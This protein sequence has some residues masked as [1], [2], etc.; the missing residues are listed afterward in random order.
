VKIPLIASH[1]AGHVAARFLTAKLMGHNPAAAVDFVDMHR[2]DSAIYGPLFSKAIEA[3]WAVFVVRFGVDPARAARVV[4]DDTW[5]VIQVAR[6][7][8]ANIDHWAIAKVT[9]AIAGPAAEARVRRLSF[10]QVIDQPTCAS[11]VDEAVRVADL[12]GWSEQRL[13]DCIVSSVEWLYEAWS[14]RP[15]WKALAWMTPL[16]SGRV[17]P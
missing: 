10:W 15:A 3:A 4:N 1:Q 17:S 2:R 5:I 6:N 16:A 9:Q 12:A 13:G 11:D 14:Y 7:A 8:G